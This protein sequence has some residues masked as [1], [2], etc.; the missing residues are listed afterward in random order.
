MPK[1]DAKSDI[2]QS[3]SHSRGHCQYPMVF[4]PKRRRKGL[5]VKTH[6]HTGEILPVEHC[7]GKCSGTC[8][9]GMAGASIESQPTPNFQS[10][11]N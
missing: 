6:G 4:V 9:C 3:L 10:L 1:E 11:T 5:S 2:Y 8:L 7:S